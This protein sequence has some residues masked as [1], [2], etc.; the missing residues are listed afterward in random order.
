MTE[1]KSSRYANIACALF[2]LLA[3]CHLY[4]VFLSIK[5]YGFYRSTIIAYSLIMIIVCPVSGIMIK[6]IKNRWT[7]LSVVLCV[8]A[9][10]EFCPKYFLFCDA[11]EW[12]GAME[13]GISGIAA[14]LMIVASIVFII[15]ATSFKKMTPETESTIQYVETGSKNNGESYGIVIGSAEKIKEYKDMLDSGIITQ[16]EFDNIKKQL[17]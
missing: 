12:W 2:V 9:V 11:V 5:L 6:R 16:D 4:D 10:L 3:L 14:L 15:A 8:F 17:L 13:G 7:F 1:K